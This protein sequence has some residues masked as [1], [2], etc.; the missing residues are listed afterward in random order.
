[1]GGLLEF[2]DDVLAKSQRDLGQM[3]L[4]FA[5][6]MNEQNNLGMDYDGQLGGNIFTLPTFSSL[7][8]NGNGNPS[9]TVNARVEAGRGSELTDVDYQITINAVT[10]GAPNQVNFTVA[11]LNPDGSA[12]LDASGN[13]ITQAYTNQTAA[14][15]TFVSIRDGLQIELPNAAAY[16]VNDRF[17]VQPSKSALTQLDVAMT[18][19]E[20]LALASPIRVQSQNANLGNA[21]V[22]GTSVTNTRVNNN[23]DGSAFTA[24][25]GIHAP[26][27]SPTGAGGVGAPARIVFT[28]C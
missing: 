10:P 22:T 16:S 4:V 12:V 27:A 14:A 7:G 18:R 6:S 15:G 25:G 2:R 11:L 21:S 8:Y 26:G 3:A 28:W 13:P 5:D 23:A 17:L 24:A 19:G 9:H 20:D 1:M